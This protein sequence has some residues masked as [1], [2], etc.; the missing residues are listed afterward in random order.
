VT[1]PEYSAEE[2]ARLGEEIYAR[3]IREKVEADH[4]GEFLVVD[5]TTGSYELDESDV[6][7]SD[8]ALAKNPDALLYFIKV[9]RP[10]AYRIGAG[11]SSAESAR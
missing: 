11:P 8:R 5:V 9:G 6:A 3:D 10:S 4:E 2:I 1:R 7:A